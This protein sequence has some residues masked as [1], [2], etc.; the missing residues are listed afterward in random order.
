M[1]FYCAGKKK[2]RSLKASISH[3][4]LSYKG[5]DAGIQEDLKWSTGLGKGLLLS[6]I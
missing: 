4:Y 1:S 2:K 5:K 3:N 6:S